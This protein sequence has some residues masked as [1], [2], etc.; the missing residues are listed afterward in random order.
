M[1]KTEGILIVK[2][3]KYIEFVNEKEFLRKCL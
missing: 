3:K 1:E 2:N